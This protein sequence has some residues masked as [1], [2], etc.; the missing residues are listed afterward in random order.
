MSFRVSITKQV[1]RRVLKDG[2]AVH[3][4]RFFVNYREPRTGE[5]KLPSFPNR[6]EA[7][8][9]R[10]TLVVEVDAGTYSP[11]RQ[12]VT[13]A[14]AV[15]HWLELKR[16]RVRPRTMNGYEH[17]C[18]HITG[19]LL[20][21]NSQERFHHTITGKKPEGA[22]ELALLGRLKIAELTTAAI[23]AWHQEVA[24]AISIYAAN[25]AKMVLGAVL[26]LAEEE[27][28][29]RTPKMPTQL[30]RGH[31]RPKKAI[32]SMEQVKLLI[33]AARNDRQYGAYYAFPFLAGTRI[34]E[35]FALLWDDIDFERNVIHIRRSQEM[36]GTIVEFTKTKAGVREVPMAP[37]LRAMLLEWRVACPRNADGELYRVFPA[38]RSS[39]RWLA[40]QTP[41]GGPLWYANFRKRIWVP[42]L[43]RL[44]LP[45]VTTH[46]AR[47]LFIST[48]Q[49]Q[50]VEVGLVAKL[51]GHANPSITLSHYTQAVR[52]GEGAIA[53][54]EQAFGA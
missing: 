10:N 14:K 50:G 6:R 30:S 42:A 2:R 26:A 27:F 17:A 47:H 46:S 40:Q 35:Q 4:T 3:Q 1:R 18:A 38:P 24:G 7:E 37:V 36:D 28:A 48:L 31:A 23:R 49:A 34:S 53:K 12:S 39:H 43:Q 22:R 19:P 13:V 15:A 25:R 33:Q 41:G 8:E 32:L 44:G 52:G 51:A 54:L 45:L 29:V 20:V 5:R 9:F 11:D 21:G 16:S